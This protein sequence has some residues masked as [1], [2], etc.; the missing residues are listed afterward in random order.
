M[1][2]EGAKKVR[3]LATLAAASACLCII[4]LVG[5]GGPSRKELES[6]D[7]DFRASTASLEEALSFLDALERFDFENGSFMDDARK[8]VSSSREMASEAFTII[9][10]L[11]SRPYGGK[12]EELGRLIEDYGEAASAAVEE[13]QSLYGPLEGLLSAIEPVMREEAAIT[14]MEAPRSDAEW[15][16]R[17]NRLRNALGPA[18]SALSSL[19]V[20]RVLEEYRGFLQELFSVLYKLVEELASRVKRGDVSSNAPDNPDFLRMQELLGSYGATVDRL[21]KNL[22]ASRLD[23]LV[24]KVELEINRLF[25]EAAR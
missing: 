14:G 22:E 15:L 24:E 25:L 7:E 4:S 23:P 19:E 11:L 17:L 13:L 10:R 1:N 3:F 16:E 21:R 18:L 6:L 20:P 5:C 2:N 8:S 9:Q 12:L